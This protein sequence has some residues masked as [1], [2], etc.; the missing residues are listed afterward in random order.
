MFKNWE[1]FLPLFLRRQF[2]G[3]KNLKK[4]TENIGWLFFDKV[5]RMGMGLVVGVRKRK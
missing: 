4:I 5:L 1:R 2:E 3:R